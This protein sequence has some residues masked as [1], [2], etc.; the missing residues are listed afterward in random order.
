MI[1]YYI[2]SINGDDINNTGTSEVSPLKTLQFLLNKIS[3]FNSDTNIYLK[4]GSYT[5]NNFLIAKIASN[6]T[7]NIIGAGIKTILKPLSSWSAANPAN[8]T[9]NINRL[10]FDMT[11]MGGT[12]VQ[13]IN[14]KLNLN[15]VAIINTPVVE[16]AT[17]IPYDNYTYKFNNCIALGTRSVLLRLSGG[18]IELHNCYGNFANGYDTTQTQWDIKNNCITNSPHFNESYKIIDSNANNKIGLYRGTFSWGNYLMRSG[19]KYFTVNSE[20][21][22]TSIHKYNALNNLNFEY[23]FNNTD[24]FTEITI[25]GETFKPIDKFDNFTIISETNNLR[26]LINGIKSMKELLVQ[27]FDINTSLIEYIR[28]INIDYTY[29]PNQ[30]DIRIV[31]SKDA[32]NTWLTISEG[33]VTYTDCI[34][35]S[36]R[37]SDFTS[38]DLLHFNAAKVTINSIG[39]KKNDLDTFNWNSI[40]AERLRFAYV[41]Y[42]DSYV[43]N[44]YINNF[45]LNY[46]EKGYMQLLKDN[47]CDIEVF[48][49]SV[50]VKSNVAN[51][52]I[53]TNIII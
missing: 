8:V 3:F 36:K 23:G 17:F 50:K 13:R 20:F 34:I 26:L 22:D 29:F 42:T 4:K 6:F 39:F 18:K 21:Y 32:G 38:D 11:N 7:L 19:E 28:N 41:L 49:H 30:G 2:D 43:N 45:S 48:D 44:P 25:D 35:P 1:E 47:E 51:P 40:D 31:F 46:D 37:Y 10:V 15:N 52:M 53:E 12:N 27:S 24:L 5:C 9:I 14:S 16:Y 33:V